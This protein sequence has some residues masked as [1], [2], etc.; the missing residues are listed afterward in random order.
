MSATLSI[1]LQNNLIET[2]NLFGNPETIAAS[3]LRRY[4]LDQ[5]LQRIEQAKERIARYE[6]KYHLPYQSF[7]QKA[8]TDAIFLEELNQSSPLWEV[9]AIEWAEHVEDVKLWQR[10]LNAILQESRLL[11][12]LN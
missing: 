11:P 1:A 6:A 8:A 2:L 5:C 3:A 12:A 7:K 10:R 4:V 9:D